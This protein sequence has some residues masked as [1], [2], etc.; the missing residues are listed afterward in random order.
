[1]GQPDSFPGSQSAVG[2]RER[3]KRRTRETIVRTALNLFTQRGF[4]GATLAQIADAAEIAP[5][6]L[7]TYFRTK[8]DIVFELH[9]VTRTSMRTR[10]VERAATETV[11]DAM[12]A[13]FSEMLPRIAT[14]DSLDTLQQRR[15][16]IQGDNG[17]LA[18]Q[19]LRFALLE[20][21]LALAFADE[22]GDSADD[23][24]VRLLAS[25]SVNGLTTV[26]NWWLKHQTTEPVDAGGLAT[27]D[28]A[29]LIR[30]ISAAEELVKTI[31]MPQAPPRQGPD[32][33]G[34]AT[35][36]PPASQPAP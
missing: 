23:L 13:W 35:A 32:D 12:T 26:W 1:M 18:G 16:I 30:L 28:V 20:D 2:L 34:P 29:Y 14:A 4:D 27:L 11:I 9:D 22:V 7:Y 19:R 31:P 17:L 3:K 24:R 6:T 15:A 5:S 21:D 25:L 36:R 10:V 8:E 33:S